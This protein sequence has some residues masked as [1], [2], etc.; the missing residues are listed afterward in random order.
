MK[1]AGKRSRIAVTAATCA[2]AAIVT[3]YAIRDLGATLHQTLLPHMGGLAL[4][5]VAV[6]VTPLVIPL[7]AVFVQEFWALRCAIKARLVT[8]Y[9]GIPVYAAEGRHKRPSATIYLSLLGPV[10]CVEGD[11]HPASLAHEEGH[12]R[13]EGLV[14]GLLNAA[15][16]S[17][18][19]FPYGL[20]LIY[21]LP[22]LIMTVLGLP[23]I[24]KISVAQ[25]LAIL[26]LT[27]SMA[28][29]ATFK[30]MALER[31]ADLY[32]YEKLGDSWR[33]HF[34]AERP[35]SRIVR[36]VLWLRPPLLLRT[37]PPDWVRASKEYYDPKLSLWHIFLKDVFGRHAPRGRPA[38]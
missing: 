34:R 24:P 37:H 12:Y 7:W 17:L 31:D 14:K 20:A 3:V 4:Y 6:L 25:S 29:L 10:I 2:A 35:K 5:I 38:A 28:L 11:V 19:Y 22:L 27:A 9:N 26:L 8:V 36:L 30:R 33:S 21:I 32:A 13:R 16:F 1:R 15:M 23:N 18:L